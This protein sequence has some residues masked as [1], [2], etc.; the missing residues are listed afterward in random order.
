MYTCTLGKY[1]FIN[2]VVDEENGSIK[3][4]A[5]ADFD[6]TTETLR[7]M[8]AAVRRTESGLVVVRKIDNTKGVSFCLIYTGEADD[9]PAVLHRFSKNLEI[10]IES[11][12]LDVASAMAVYDEVS[13]RDGKFDL[14]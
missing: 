4:F 10:E 3:Q 9:L 7:V 12:R 8:R 5:Y 2:V 1:E 6:M 13:T 11:P 14:G